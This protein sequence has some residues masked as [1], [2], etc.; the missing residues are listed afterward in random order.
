MY[1][2]ELEA[3]ISVRV[4]VGKFDLSMKYVDPGVVIFTFRIVVDPE[5]GNGAF[6]IVVIASATPSENISLL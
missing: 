4:A 2:L 5:N 3:K 1:L 6:E